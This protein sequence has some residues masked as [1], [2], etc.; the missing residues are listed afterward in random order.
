[1]GSA[2]AAGHTLEAVV[3]GFL[4]L[5]WSGGRR[6]FDTPSGVIRFALIGLAS[7]AIGSAIGLSALG[8][9]GFA[10]WA[11]LVPMWRTWWLR[12]V[13]GALVVT[14]VLVLWFTPDWQRYH[15]ANA[16]ETGALFLVTGAVGLAAFGPRIDDAFES[17]ALAFLAVV[18]LA[19][20][21]LRCG[22]RA[23]ASVAF[24]LAGFAVW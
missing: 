18:P 6:T 9:V 8:L 16:V 3:G 24:I 23:T 21:A 12:D 5:R 7:T 19:W 15:H 22:Q 17:S 14:P 10:E 13:A 1:M 2:M 20:A 4:A 11:G